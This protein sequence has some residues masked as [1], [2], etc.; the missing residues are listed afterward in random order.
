MIRKLMKKI[1]F[2]MFCIYFIPM[3]F[4]VAIVETIME[5]IKWIKYK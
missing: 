3:V 4:L 5:E 2:G 1:G